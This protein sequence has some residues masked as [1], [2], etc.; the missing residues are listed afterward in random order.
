MRN[1]ET[2]T[3]TSVTDAAR[4]TIRTATPRH[5]GGL[6]V[7]VTFGIGRLTGTPP[8]GQDF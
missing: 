5:A 2:T 3:A 4:V 7:A 6:A 1:S 8:A